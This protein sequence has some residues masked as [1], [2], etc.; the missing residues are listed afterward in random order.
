MEALVRFQQLRYLDAA[1]RLGSLRQTALELG[2]AQPSVSEQIRRLEEDL[3]VV[4]LIRSGSGVRASDAA[5]LI[6]PHLRRAL[7]AEEAIYQEASAISGARSGRVR[8]GSISSASQRILPVVVRRFQAEHPNISFQVTEAGSLTISKEVASGDF[9]LGIVSRFWRGPLQYH[10]LRYEDLAKAYIALAVPSK[11]PLCRK[12]KVTAAE[13]VNEAMVV[14]HQGY[15]LREAYELLAEVAKVHPVYYTDSAETAY[16]VVAA[17]VGLTLVSSLGSTFYP[18][19]I[20]Q[21]PID[22]DWAETR[23][24]VVLREDEQPTPAVR[25]FLRILR[26]ESGGAPTTS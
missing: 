1:L 9:D 15:L 19:N 11:H 23:M 25:A 20:E 8:L 24:S 7:R 21:L 22:E 18:T 26:E 17:G 4:L 16:R 14:F 2:V 3:G 6:L 10:G 5:G 13:V 12:L